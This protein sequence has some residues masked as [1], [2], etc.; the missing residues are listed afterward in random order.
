MKRLT[1]QACVILFQIARM[2]CTLSKAG[3]IIAGLH[4]AIPEIACRK[5]LAR[6][7]PN[8][9]HW[10]RID[11]PVFLASQAKRTLERHTLLTNMA[12]PTTW[13]IT[14]AN[15]GI[16][17]EFVKQILQN[18]PEDRVVAGAR[19]T[20]APALLSLQEQHGRRLLRVEIDLL[21]PAALPV[22]SWQPLPG[23]PGPRK[24]A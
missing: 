13:L 1:Q 4:D 7:K 9:G 11:S 20:E 15:R 10:H 3:E 17:L 5:V 8:A 12:S 22:G 16:G 2:H 14:G 23:L 18:S 6:T 24:R 21:K 19:S